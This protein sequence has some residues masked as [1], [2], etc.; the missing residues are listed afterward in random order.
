MSGKKTSTW[1]HRLCCILI[2]LFLGLSLCLFTLHRA[3]TAETAAADAACSNLAQRSARFTQAVTDIAAEVGFDPQTALAFYPADRQERIARDG[4][5]RLLSL[6]NGTNRPAP[7][8]TAVRDGQTLTEAILEDPLFEGARHVARDQGQAAVER[9][10]ARYLLPVR[11]SLVGIAEEHLE[12]VVRKL[13]SVWPWTETVA[14]GLAG[15]ALLISLL[16]SLISRKQARGLGYA[17]AGI[18]GAGL[19]AAALMLIPLV[20]LDLPGLAGEVSPLFSAELHVWL[21]SVLRPMIVL[22][23]ALA[24]L[25]WAAA[26]IIGRKGGHAS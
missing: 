10:A 22:C 20:S 9:A 11:T 26:L 15:L 4:A 13:A 16:L 3:L 12:T 17:A 25:G 24:V 23:A 7:D 19:G 5:V 21:T 6:V 8:V 18:A 1:A 14:W 2:A